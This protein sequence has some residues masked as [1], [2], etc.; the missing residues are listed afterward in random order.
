M[1][2]LVVYGEQSGLPFY[3]RQLSG[4]VPDVKT[5]IKLLDD[6][7]ALGIDNAK[8]GMDRGFYSKANIDALLG[9]HLK[10]LIGIRIGIKLVRTNLLDHMEELQQ[11]QNYD[12]NSGVSG[13]TVKTEWDYEQV[14]PYKKDTL[15]AKRR[16]YLHLYFNGDRHAED[17]R[18]LDK[19]LGELYH[20]LQ[21][22]KH[23]EAHAKDYA[24]FFEVKTTPKRGR[25][26]TPKD[27]AI[28]QAKQFCGYWALLTNEKMTAAQALHIYRSKD[29]IENGFGNV[30][31][32]LNGHRLLVSS[33][34][35]LNGKLF[36]QFVGLILVAGINQV[37]HNKQLY[38][39]YSLQ[40]LLDRLDEVEQFTAPGRAPKVRE[41]QARSGYNL[42]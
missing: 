37:M 13:I 23:I 16:V 25:Q 34:K 2:L 12:D 3:Y 22:G 39:Q 20:E 9:Q 15:Q 18:K 29:I 41:V 1:N 32:R 17:V 26:V 5:V 35:S 31:D 28:K 21:T 11:F 8:L 19:R 40:Q 42:R 38:R 10:F 14:R 6:L 36:V 30:K 7:E 33:E 27:G 4:S 24:K